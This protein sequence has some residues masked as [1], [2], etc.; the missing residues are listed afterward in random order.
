MI[1]EQQ[2]SF[3]AE[4]ARRSRTIASAADSTVVFAPSR[5]VSLAPFIQRAAFRVFSLPL[6]LSR[7][8]VATQAGQEPRGVV[9]WRRASQPKMATLD[10]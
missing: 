3:E 2:L 1:T 9:A 4:A 6:T 7:A 10:Q 5:A 8:R